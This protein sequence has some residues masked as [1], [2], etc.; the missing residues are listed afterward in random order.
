MRKLILLICLVSHLSIEAQDQIIW[1]EPISIASAV[2]GN[3]HPRIVVD[4]Q[5]NPLVL[6]YNAENA[7]FARSNGT[8]FESPVILNADFN[9]A[10][11]SWMGPDIA[12]HG[13]TVYVV[14]KE[15][16]EH[17]GHLWSIASFDGGIT[18]SDPVQIDAIGDS[19]SRFPVVATD[20][21]GHPIVGFMK[22]NDEFGDARWMVSRSNDFGNTF[23]SDV[24]ASGWSSTSSDVCDCCPG[25]VI[26]ADNFVVMLYRDNN[27]NIRDTWAGISR[28]GGLSFEEGVNIDQQNWM[29]MACPASGPDGH[30]IGDTLYSVFMNGASGQ[31]RV[32]L[33]KTSLSNVSES[34]VSLLTDDNDD[35]GLQNFPRISGWGTSLGMVWRQ[36]VNNNPELVVRITNDIM[37]GIPEGYDT[38]TLDN[39]TNADIAIYDHKVFVVWEDVSSGTVKFISGDFEDITRVP[40]EIPLDGLT[41]LPNPSSFNWIISGEALKGGSTLGLYDQTGKILYSKGISANDSKQSVEIDNSHLAGGIY[42]LRVESTAGR[43]I[44]TLVKN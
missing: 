32:Y 20:E 38:I 28:D 3:D 21:S 27:S 40:R 42:F 34:F 33:S 36:V 24:L 35:I 23:S 8:A 13:D 43:G 12:S 4:A 15:I 25:T 5:G 7:M 17:H 37:M 16:P 31:S 18:F 11:A 41:I 1:S 6:W 22:F 19:L 9:I 14:F 10:G 44:W 39:A 26:S 30:V 2:T 29:I